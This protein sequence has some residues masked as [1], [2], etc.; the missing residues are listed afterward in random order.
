MA[1]RAR[2]AQCG[3][4]RHRAF[5]LGQIPRS[6][7]QAEVVITAPAELAA[8]L[9][10]LDGE[11]RFALLVSKAEVKEGAELSVEVKVSGGEKMRTLLAL[12]RRCRHGGRTRNRL[13]PLRRKCRRPRGKP[14]LRLIPA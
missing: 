11:L 10:A 2:S 4:R 1:G 12:H 7:L 6:S 3:N 8:A 13:R 14:P 9:S 5:A